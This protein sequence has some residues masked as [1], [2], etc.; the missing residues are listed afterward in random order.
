MSIIQ[1]AIPI[2]RT[3]S[4]EQAFLEA[5]KYG[6]DDNPDHPNN[7]VAEMAI[8]D[9]ADLD[10]R[11]NE[12]YT[13]FDVYVTS[14]GITTYRVFTLWKADT[15]L[16]KPILTGDLRLIDSITR[17]QTFSKSTSQYFDFWKC[18]YVNGGGFVNIFNHPDTERNTFK[19][20]IDAGW[21]EIFEKLDYDVA[22][23]LETLLPLVVAHDGEWF[24]LEG[25][26]K[27][28]EYPETTFYKEPPTDMDDIPFE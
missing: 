25:I 8:D 9:I 20:L 5:H 24:K 19:I 12:G 13:L 7:V 26:I 21:Q 22:I 28:E 3:L 16:K 11:L 14:G 17:K 1:I 2:Y 4:T 27:L 15:S 23:E 6:T 10:A 18:S